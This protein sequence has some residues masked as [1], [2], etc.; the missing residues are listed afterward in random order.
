[1]S[2]FINFS[3]ALLLLAPV[4]GL[5]PT[6][7][8]VLSAPVPIF[9]LSNTELSSG[10]GAIVWDGVWGSEFGAYFCK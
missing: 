1:M 9:T 3:T 5:T 10:L 7:Y 2:D 6:L 4:L 8:L